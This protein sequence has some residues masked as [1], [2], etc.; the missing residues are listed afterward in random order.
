MNGTP[1]QNNSHYD[2]HSI[3]PA[4]LI[5]INARVQIT[6]RNLYPP[7]GLFN[8]SIGTV[9]DIVFN[10]NDNPNHDDLPKY[11]VVHFEQYIG[12][13]WNNDDPKLVPIP[14]IEN[15]CKKKCCTQQFVPL[16]LAFAKTIHTFQGQNVGKV[17]INQP[18][19]TFQK[20]I[21]DPGL[22]SFEGTNPGIFYSLSG[23]ATTIG[24][25]E[26]PLS[27]ALYFTGKN[28]NTDRISHLQTNAQGQTY[29]KL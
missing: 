24:E 15:L 22:K 5:C 20:I 9:K 16:Q 4:C 3:P 12:P 21:C 18:Q 17:P 2:S 29:K 14:V 26:S 7:W 28:M 25:N 10:Q 13:A 8:G 11:I 27:S 1:T 23:R 6:G 19:N